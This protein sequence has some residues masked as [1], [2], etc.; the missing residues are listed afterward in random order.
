MAVKGLIGLSSFF[1]ISVSVSPAPVFLAD[2]PAEPGTDIPLYVAQELKWDNGIRGYSICWY[3]GR[4]NW[5]GVDFDA[6]SVSATPKIIKIKVFTRDDW[7]N[8][9]YDGF[10]VAIYSWVNDAPGSIIWPTDGSAEYFKPEGL[11]HGDV[12]AELTVGWVCSSPRF[13][14]AVNQFYDE[15][16]CDPLALDTYLTPSGHNW[17][18]YK[19]TWSPFDPSSLNIDNENLMIRVVV[20]ESGSAAGFDGSRTPASVGRIKA[21]FQ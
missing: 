18:C 8:D 16:N 15:P 19:G 21:L 5:L 12:W 17:M 20:D 11:P 3:D 2:G 9:R 14:V 7:P 6:S 4:D 1:F 10:Y 13:V